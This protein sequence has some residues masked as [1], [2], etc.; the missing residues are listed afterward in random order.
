M[1]TGSPRREQ[2]WRTGT[3]P[4]ERQ[5][6]LGET[7]GSLR[8]RLWPFCGEKRNAVVKGTKSAVIRTWVQVP[9]LR[10]SSDTFPGKSC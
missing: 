8:E 7:Q 4:A 1:V 6:C 2:G 5:S 3:V 9:A 10:L